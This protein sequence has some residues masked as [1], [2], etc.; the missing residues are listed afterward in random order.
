MKK[1]E[2]KGFTL[3]ELSIGLFLSSLIGTALYNAFFVTN[4][5]VS[6]TDNFIFDRFRASLVENQFEKDLAGIFIPE[7]NQIVTS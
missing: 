3:I 1:N 2:T 7:S 6:I 5:V 4:R